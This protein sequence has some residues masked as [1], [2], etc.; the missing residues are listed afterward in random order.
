MPVA[1]HAV[2]PS[3]CMARGE[4]LCGQEQQREPRPAR[5]PKIRLSCSVSHPGSGQEQKPHPGLAMLSVTAANVLLRL[6]QRS[7]HTLEARV[8][9]HV[10]SFFYGRSLFNT[11]AEDR[12]VQQRPPPLILLMRAA[13]AGQKKEARHPSPQPL[14]SPPAGLSLIPMLSRTRVSKTPHITRRNAL[15]DKSRVE[16]RRQAL[17][18]SR[19]APDTTVASPSPLTMAHHTKAHTPGQ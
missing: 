11:R 14:L 1:H 12:A 18:L 13:E 5:E 16:A 6:P 9:E 2:H 10:H 15:R 19:A 17:C 4:T 8:G 3:P 7:R